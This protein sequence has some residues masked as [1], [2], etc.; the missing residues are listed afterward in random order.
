[1]QILYLVRE[2]CTILLLFLTDDDYCCRIIE[3]ML[4]TS[5]T[6]R[7]P[8]IPYTFRGMFNVLTE[9]LKFLNGEQYFGTVSIFR[10]VLFSRV[11]Y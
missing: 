10:H 1:M 9:M 11:M 6:D 8:P 7:L 3:F 4:Q 5:L 2:T